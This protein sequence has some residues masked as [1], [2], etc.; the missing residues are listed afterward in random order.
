MNQML[1]HYRQSYRDHAGWFTT[2]QSLWLNED[3]EGG[4]RLLHCPA[5]VMI[6][7]YQIHMCAV[8]RNLAQEGI[9]ARVLCAAS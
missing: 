6:L 9:K 5:E 2:L 7:F 3:L 4:T 1:E 8:V